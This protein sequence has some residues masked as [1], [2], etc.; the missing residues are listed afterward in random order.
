MKNL[1]KRI[2]S[3]SSDFGKWFTVKVPILL[4]ILASSAEAL[5]ATKVISEELIPIWVKQYLAIGVVISK[6]LGHLTVKKDNEQIS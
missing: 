5:E 4:I 1:I 3:E 2:K 6:L